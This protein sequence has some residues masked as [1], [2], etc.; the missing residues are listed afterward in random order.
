MSN[1]YTI[2]EAGI[3]IIR[4]IQKECEL[5]KLVSNYAKLLGIDYLEAFQEFK[6]ELWGLYGVDI[7]KLEGSGTDYQKIVSN[8]LYDI[9]RDV[10]IAL[11]WDKGNNSAVTQ[12]ADMMSHI[13]FYNETYK[14]FINSIPNCAVIDDMPCKRVVK[15]LTNEQ[16]DAINEYASKHSVDPVE[17]M[18][19]L[20]D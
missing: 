4:V 7:S 18:H 8:G 6:E 3:S 12:L 15:R 10:M 1:Q 20:F 17:A 5:K 11:M 13:L 16:M 19:V 2:N 9:A 14:D